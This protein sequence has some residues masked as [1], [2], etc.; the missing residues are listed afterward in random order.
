MLEDRVSPPI[1]RPEN[2][3]NF[4]NLLWLSRQLIISTEPKLHKHFPNTLTPNMAKNHE[5]SAYFSTNAILAYVTHQ[6][7]KCA[8]FQT[9]DAIGLE[10]CK[11]T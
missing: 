3:V 6:N 11:Q 9:K 8:G 2:S 5:T 7:S 1:W 10:S 4:W